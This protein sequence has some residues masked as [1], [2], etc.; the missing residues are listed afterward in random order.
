MN[1]IVGDI[2]GEISKLKKLVRWIKSIDTSPELIFIGDYLDKGEDAKATLDY[3][4]KLKDQVPCKFLIGN[5][6]YCWINASIYEEY[7]LKYGGRN[8]IHSFKCKDVKETQLCLLTKYADF[9]SSLLN[10]CIIDSYLVC[11]SGV[12]PEFYLE[13]ELDC[14]KQESFLFNRYSFI[15]NEAL[16]QDRYIV[17]FGHTGFF[18]PYV[19]DYKIGI[20]TAACFLEEQPL[21]CFCTDTATF[22]D[23][24]N[25]HYSLDEIK[26]EF[27]P[28]ILRNKPWRTYD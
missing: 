27:C 23:S 16:F 6:E 21:T 9:F 8:T 19:D 22:F 13:H 11:H 4:V 18:R 2:H 3:L 26:G 25:E 14:I 17:V 1:Y 20:D 7:L 28:N 12:P 10:F 5:H 15:R 24:N